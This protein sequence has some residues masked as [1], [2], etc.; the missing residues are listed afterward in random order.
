MKSIFVEF[1][2]LNLILKLKYLFF[3]PFTLISIIVISLLLYPKT[4]LTTAASPS[5][6]KMLDENG[7]IRKEHEKIPSYIL[8][9]KLEENGIKLIFK[10]QDSEEN[11]KPFLEYMVQNPDKIDFTFSRNWGGELPN[12]EKIKALSI[13]TVGA[14]PFI[15]ITKKNKNDIRI[16]KDLKG[17]K[18]AFSSSPEGKSKNPVFSVGGDKPSEYS[19]DI[20]QEKFFKLA[21]ITPENTKLINYWPNK[22]SEDDDWDIILTSGVP[23]KS[24]QNNLYAALLRDEIQ[25][26]E[27]EDIEAIVKNLPQTI[28][29]N[30]SK[31]L[32]N[33]ENNY[34][35]T[36]FK[37]IG[38]THSVFVRKDMD[39]THILILAQVLKDMYGKAS[40]FA[41]KDQYPNF[42]A[43]EIFDP[44]NVAEKFYREGEN[45]ILRRYFSPI[46][47]AFLTKLFF[48]LGPIFIIGIP[49]LTV[50]PNAINKYFQMKINK[51]YEEIYNI[52]KIIDANNVLDITA[53]ND[54]LQKLDSIVRSI[55]FPLVHDEFVQQ[56]FIVREHILLI[57]RKLNR[58][59]LP[60]VEKSVPMV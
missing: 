17:K 5:L 33:P 27:F 22:I 36:S 37:T 23:S 42:N 54:R 9:N 55:K 47:S 31:S 44:S 15:F 12:D 10:A 34:P 30:V 46:S 40:R 50:F 24:S 7:K 6:I 58:I 19:S 56:I 49:L 28:L 48:I 52:E 11:A 13:G 45:S 4:D 3:I 14:S 16:L 43:V 25:F 21:G 38:L 8:Q 59:R 20:F 60:E 53:I 57:Q 2:K 18:I 39:P 32:F 41:V 35:S 51:Y 1:S 26:F 29:V